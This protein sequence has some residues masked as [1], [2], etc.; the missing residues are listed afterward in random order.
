MSL[1]AVTA[2]LLLAWTVV[3]VMRSSSP[4]MEPGDCPWCGGSCEFAC[5]GSSS[6]RAAHMAF[7]RRIT[8]IE[9]LGRAG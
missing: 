9:R 7:R 1:L 5:E 2:M 4:A 8:E 6:Q 3:E